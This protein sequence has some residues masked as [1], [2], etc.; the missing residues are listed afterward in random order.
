[1]TFRMTPREGHEPKCALQAPP[2]CFANLLSLPDLGRDLLHGL[3]IGGPNDPGLDDPDPIIVHLLQLQVD[4]HLFEEDQLAVVPAMGV[5]HPVLIHR[6]TDTC[7][8]ESGEGQRATDF[9]G[10]AARGRLLS[11]S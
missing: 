9:F 7:H 10:W 3:V 11:P 2:V 8:Q 4:V 6:P 1:M 5:Q